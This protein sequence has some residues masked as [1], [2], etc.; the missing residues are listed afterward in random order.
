MFQ[1]TSYGRG[2]INSSLLNVLSKGLVFFVNLIIASTFG[3]SIS[4]DIYFFCYSCIILVVVFISGITNGVIIPEYIHLSS[5]DG[6]ETLASSFINRTLYF[7]I[8]ILSLVAVI[9]VIDP[10]TTLGFISNF[11]AS[12]LEQERILIILAIPVLVLQGTTT[13]FNDILVSKKYFTLPM[14]VA[15][16]NSILIL[17][18]VLLMGEDI[19]IKSIFIANILAYLASLS[20]QIYLFRK[21][22]NW[23]FLIT[24]RAFN[25]LV[26]QNVIL[27][28][29]G[30]LTT[31]M[32]SYIPIFLLSKYSEGIITAL[33]YGLRI[34]E[35]PIAVFVMHVANIILVKFTELN[36]INQL[37]ELSDIFLRAT[38]LLFMVLV[39]GSILASLFSFDLT[40]LLF[41][42]GAM[43]QGALKE[44]SAFLKIL[45]L[46]TPFYAINI[47][48]SKLFI[49]AK[50]IR[51]SVIYQ[52]ALNA[53]Y[54]FLLFLFVDSMGPI[55]FAWAYLIYYSFNSIL[56]LLFAKTQFA[57]FNIG[58]VAKYQLLIILL[59]IA[60]VAGLNGM[61]NYKVTNFSDIVVFIFSYLIIYLTILGIVDNQIFSQLYS[62]IKR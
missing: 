48:I 56:I 28:S 46:A 18:L 55:G 33:N 20:F 53:A 5:I 60:I 11:K 12:T 38:K 24:S 26:F 37:K 3:A 7:V 57:F 31:S 45:V 42:R 2:I 15:L 29:S 32:S 6:Q 62:Y 4:T 49:A 23:N 21:Y 17:S 14:I 9:V 54:I 13:F 40:I 43:D 52:I 30:W 39:P 10:V 16:A 22:F 51:I 34:S 44:T 19:G 61:F 1:S 27:V 41:G 36:A 47:L 59:N 8:S 35:I 25:K 50:K 58:K